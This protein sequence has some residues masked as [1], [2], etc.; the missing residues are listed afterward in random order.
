MQIEKKKMPNT[1]KGNRHIYLC[2]TFLDPLYLVLIYD[3]STTSIYSAS[4]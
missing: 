1:W 4:V 2:L 3:L